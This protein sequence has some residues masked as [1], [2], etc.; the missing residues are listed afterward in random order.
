M[1]SRVTVRALMLTTHKDRWM[2]VSGKIDSVRQV[3]ELYGGGREVMFRVDWTD[4]NPV[5][6]LMYFDE[7]RAEG[8]DTKHPG[9]LIHVCGKIDSVP[10]NLIV[11]RQCELEHL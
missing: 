4:T 9:E 2:H 7:K 10:P 8:L 6:Y 11:L 5:A 3:H 1:W